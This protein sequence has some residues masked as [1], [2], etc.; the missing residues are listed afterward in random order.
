MSVNIKNQ[1]VEQLLEEVTALTGESKTEA[2]R[3]SLEERRDRL[4]R[5]RADLHP[6]DRLRRLLVREIWPTI[7]DDVRGTRLSKAEEEEILGLGSDG[8]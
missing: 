6:A 2:V 3:R 4:A 8:A 5:S 7:P 1:R